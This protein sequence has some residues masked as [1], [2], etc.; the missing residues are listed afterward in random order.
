MKHCGQLFL[1]K[2]L[3]LGFNFS[4]ATATISIQSNPERASIFSIDEQG[5][6]I[7]LGEAPLLLNYDQV[8]TGNA[9]N[10]RLLVQ[11]TQYT[12]ESIY[13]HRP[14]LP[15]SMKYSVNLEAIAPSPTNTDINQ[16]ES[17]DKLSYSELAQGV[18]EIQTII[19]R[20]EFDRARSM[21]M[22]LLVRYPFVST[23]HDLMGNTHFHNGQ[24]AAALASYEASLKLNPENIN[25]RGMVQ[26]LR[27]GI[28][29]PADLGGR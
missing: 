1:A 28:Q 29:I 2:V 15:S 5:N 9:R 13:I 26:S 12:Q 27:A 22:V 23:L 25:T 6:R 24:I 17:T 18:A 19:R 16:C 10:V 11:K 7:N 20:R 4:C 3:L 8:F 21:L 14:L